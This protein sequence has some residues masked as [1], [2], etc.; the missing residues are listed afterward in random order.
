MGKPLYFLPPVTTPSTQ[1]ELKKVYIKLFSLKYINLC[2]RYCVT[3]TQ[4]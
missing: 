3:Y 4:T 1:T 2:V